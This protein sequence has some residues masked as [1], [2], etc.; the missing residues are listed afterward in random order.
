MQTSKEGVLINIENQASVFE[1]F[2]SIL[3]ECP[4]SDKTKQM[5]DNYFEVDPNFVEKNFDTRIRR[6]ITLIDKNLSVRPNLDTLSQEVGLSPSH[7]MAIFKKETGVT[8]SR[9]RMKYIDSDT[10]PQIGLEHII[11]GHFEYIDSN[12]GFESRWVER[13]WIATTKL[14]DLKSRMSLR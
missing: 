12:I 3:D 10:F 6:V 1:L 11:K 2:Q 8:I 7:M 13:I 14:A 5:I 4:H 9:Y